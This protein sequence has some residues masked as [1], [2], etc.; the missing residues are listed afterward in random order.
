MAMV[1]KNNQLATM[2]LGELNKNIVEKGKRMTRLATGQKIV[3]A[4]DGASEFSITEK[5]QVQLRSLGQDIENT[6]TGRSMLNVGAG[7][8]E[9][10]VEELRGM[11][12]LAINAANDT[13]T[14]ADRATIQ[15]EF[16]QKK[17][18]IAD[19]VATTNYNG[20][21]LL[22]G[23][24]ARYHKAMVRGSGGSGGTSGT[25]SVST[26]V[27]EPNDTATLIASG[28]YTISAAG[29]YVLGANF[30]GEIN[31]ADGLVG[32]KI[33]QATS[34]PLTN[35]FINGPSSGS[36]NLWIDGLN[37]NNNSD[38]SWIKFSGSDNVLS[39][40]GSN[41]F[42]NNSRMS[43]AAINIGGGLTVEGTGSLTINET[44]PDGAMIG[45][46]QGESSSANLT[47]NSG[48]YTFT[49]GGS[50]TSPASGG[51]AA[52][53]GS[54]SEGAC[55]GDIMINGG[56]FDLFTSGAGAPLGCGSHASAGNITIKNAAVTGV[57]D[58]GACIGSGCGY[59]TVGDIFIEDSTINVQSRPVYSGASESSTINGGGGAGIGS[60]GY[61]TA[62]AAAGDIT[63]RNSTVNAFSNWGA[64]IGSGHKSHAGNITVENVNGIV[65]SRKG[66]NIGKGYDGTIGDINT[67]G[68]GGS[69]DSFHEELIEGT[70]L[71]IHTGTKANQHMRCYIEDLGLKALGIKDAEVTTQE[72]A[73]KLLGNPR[74]HHEMGV[75]DKAISYAL[76]EATQ[77]GAYMSRLEQTQATLTIN[78]ENTTAAESII[79]DA[80]MAA[81]MTAMAKANILTQSSQAM[82]AQANQVSSSVLDLLG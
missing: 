9:K 55:I 81:E 72:K 40:R 78:Q 45:T 68:S 69:D 70:P 10:I 43:K 56:T 30:S 49:S 77:V 3:G 38:R 13:N 11:K 75:L 20:K 39:I 71:I 35:V 48:T 28:P 54:G 51:Y 76:G 27:I 25:G 66:E 7:G 2:S 18:D 33:Q 65:T 24:Y 82:L 52:L 50:R 34:A 53:I 61:W 23:T 59:A 8:I 67:D 22:D 37:I 17:Q 31:I 47:I 57:A 74:D 19:I 58:D 42:S 44:S 32:V 36:A 63:I 79:R 62:A 60:G 12:Q 5:M 80:D 15:K 14:D 26:G 6:K 46:D 64:G 29:V 4:S 16:D 21:L 1:V 41:T 73:T